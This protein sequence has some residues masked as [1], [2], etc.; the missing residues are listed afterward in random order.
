MMFTATLP[1]T[2]TWLAIAVAAVALVSCG[3]PDEPAQLAFIAEP[4]DYGDDI[5]LDLYW[6]ACE[7]ASGLACDTLWRIAPVGSAYEAFAANCGGR[8]PAL[9]CEPAPAVGSSLPNR[10]E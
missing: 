6:E 9:S 7:S 10:L 5:M 3:G 2:R 1:R 4:Q 8:G